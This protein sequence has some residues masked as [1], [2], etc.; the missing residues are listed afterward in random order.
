MASPKP[1]NMSAL[2]AAFA[3]GDADAI[4]REKKAYE[5]QLA[6]EGIEASLFRCPYPLQHANLFDEPCIF[7]GR[8]KP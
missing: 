7:C 5:R 6:A 3:S 2:E 1:E 8:V 4:W